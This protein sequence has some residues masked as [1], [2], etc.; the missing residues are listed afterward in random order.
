MTVQVPAGTDGYRAALV[1]V[2]V[3]DR[4]DRAF[5]RVV[6]RDPVGMLEGILTSQL[7]T[8]PASGERGLRY[9]RGSYSAALTPKGMMVADLHVVHGPRD[10][11]GLLLGLT[12]SALGSFLSHLHRFLPPRLAR[13]FDDT[14][15][16]RALTVAGPAAAGLL[17]RE[18]L[19]LR[20]EEREL[21]ALSDSAWV[22]ANIGSVGVLVMRSGDLATPSFDV[23]ADPAGIVVL[24]GRLIEAGAVPLELTDRDTLRVEAGR[25]AWGSEL[26][27]RT[28][29]PEAG[30]DSRVIDHTKGCYT[31]Q[32]VIVRIRDR[33]HVNRHLRGLKLGSTTPVKAGTRLWIPGRDAPV[34]TIT[35]AVNSPRAGES[36]GLGY[37]RREIEVP[38]TVCVNGPEGPVVTVVGLQ[39]HKRHEWWW[40]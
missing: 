20:W 23:V 19:G 12:A 15:R 30:I 1:G 38:S 21:T 27:E 16:A 24:R 13:A 25:P 39:A 4:P 2:A 34:G 18:A 10:S 33:G 9:G 31:G 29:P 3:A 8:S 6:G 36:L 28:L 14:G 7:P 17:A 35:T 32:E 26:D 5:V 40:A 22:W 37:L 11:D